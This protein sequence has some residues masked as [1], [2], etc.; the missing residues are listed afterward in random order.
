MVIFGLILYIM[1]L[2]LIMVPR[3]WVFTVL[4]CKSACTSSVTECVRRITHTEVGGGVLRDMMA[5]NRP[6]HIRQKLYAGTSHRTFT[7]G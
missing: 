2:M 1:T 6:Y 3:A 4:I 7:M 5:G